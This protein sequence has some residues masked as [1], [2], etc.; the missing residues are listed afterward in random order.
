MARRRAQSRRKENEYVP[1]TILSSLALK[2]KGEG[3]TDIEEEMIEG[4]REGE[5][6]EARLGV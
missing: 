5:R 2:G 1:T 4:G 6:E 3:D